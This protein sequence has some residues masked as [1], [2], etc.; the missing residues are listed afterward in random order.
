MRTFKHKNHI[1]MINRKES[2]AHGFVGEFV[3]FLR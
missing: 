3:S 1:D 2:K